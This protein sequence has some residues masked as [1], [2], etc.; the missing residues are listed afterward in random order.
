MSDNNYVLIFLP[1]LCFYNVYI[2]IDI[3]F[4]VLF[5]INREN[6]VERYRY[7]ENILGIKILFLFLLVQSS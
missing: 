5:K 4:T 7:T 1:H 2:F 6:A 3:T